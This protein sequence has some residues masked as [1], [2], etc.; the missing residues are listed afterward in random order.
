MY[1]INS[2]RMIALFEQRPAIRISAKKMLELLAP[3]LQ[4]L[5][6]L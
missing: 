4:L 3:V 1:Y 2:Q 5:S 6:C